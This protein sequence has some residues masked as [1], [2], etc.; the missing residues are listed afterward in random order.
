M[1]EER[2]AAEAQLGPLKGAAGQWASCVRA[3][4][5]ATATTTA[6]LELDSNEGAVSMAL[7]NFN[8]PGNEGTYLAVGTAQGLA[9]NP[10][11]ADGALFVSVTA[12][13][14]LPPHLA[15]S[16]TSIVKLAYDRRTSSRLQA[17]IRA[18]ADRWFHSVVCN[19]GR[20]AL[21]RAAAQDA[22]GR[23]SGRSGTFQGPA[24]GR[25]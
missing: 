7:C 25:H 22:R 11:Q 23:H 3:I 16:L 10:R 4:D 12:A 2:A 9:F 1:D 5:P 18:V 15:W 6:V 24:A 17:D 19:T 13:P 21:T 8:S 20:R 14:Q